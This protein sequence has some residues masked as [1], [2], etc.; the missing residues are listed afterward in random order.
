MRKLKKQR[1]ITLVALVITIIILLILAGISIAALTNQ[2]LFGQANRAKD[3]TAQ[4]AAEENETLENYLAQMNAYDTNNPKVDE[5][6]FKNVDK[7]KTNPEAAMPKRAI[8]LEA[9][10]NKGIVIKDSNENEW[11][12]VEVPKTKVFVTAT[13]SDDYDNIENDLISYALEYRNGAEGQT[14]NWID[15]WYAID[16]ET[17]VTARTANLTEQQ[18]TLNT[19]CGLT[20]DE[21]NMAYKK[22]LSSVYTNGG[23][24]ISR[25]EAGIEIDNTDSNQN[26][27][28][29]VRNEH[30][31]ITSSSPKAV[32]QSNRML[33]NYLYC[34]EAQK[35]ASAMSTDSNKT[36]SLL[37]GIQWD[38]TCKFLQDKGKLSKEQLKSGDNVGSTNWGN[39][40]NSSII[41]TKG[42]Y[43]TDPN[44]SNNWLNI[45]SG[46]KNA[47][48]LLTT[49]ASEDINK[50]NIYDLAG[51][52]WEYTL[53]HATTYENN[54]CAIRGGSFNCSGANN[55]AACRH[56]NNVIYN[57]C[58]VGIRA[59]LY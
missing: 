13:K 17:L 21:Y 33:Y 52:E 12:W 14:Y 24:W 27:I 18:K 28:S 58:D 54:P 26:E 7:T 23:F 9:D 43:N 25:Y 5:D 31:D 19:G 56:N 48:M 8:V 16:G 29:N 6:I 50:M 4:K 3:L 59:A 20:Y 37:F 2:G 45:T 57:S 36:S 35:L 1:G 46:A 42:K 51:N 22:M 41:L 39:Y 53:E 38:L 49:G 40:T 44:S 15:E 34:N 30:S 11:T 10:A 47:Q 32:S 55:P